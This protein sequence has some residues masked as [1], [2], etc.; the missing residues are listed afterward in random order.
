MRG[1]KLEH[2]TTVLE[3]VRM[4]TDV[5]VITTESNVHQEGSRSRQP[6]Q[7]QAQVAGVSNRGAGRGYLGAWSSTMVAVQH[8]EQ[9]AAPSGAAPGAG[10]STRSRSA[11]GAEQPGAGERCKQIAPGAARSST[12]GNDP[13]YL[14]RKRQPGRMHCGAKRGPCAIVGLW[15]NFPGAK[16]GMIPACNTRVP[17]GLNGDTHT[18]RMN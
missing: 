11:P 3:F 8:Q 1:E 6:E 7:E 14:V 2:L 13:C 12:R 15:E 18:A 16:V 9:D 10:A 5:V 17:P 4:Q